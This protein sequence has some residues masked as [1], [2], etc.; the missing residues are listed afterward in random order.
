MRSIVD[1][2]NI[3]IHNDKP[4]NISGRHHFEAMDESFPSVDCQVLHVYQT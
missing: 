1:G 3:N 2:V 4:T